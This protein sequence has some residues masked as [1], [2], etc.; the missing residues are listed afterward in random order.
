MSFLH[1]RKPVDVQD[2][3]IDEQ[4]QEEII[5]QFESEAAASRSRSRWLACSL[6]A[7]VGMLGVVCLFKGLDPHT[8]LEFHSLLR[9]GLGT[10]GLIAIQLSTLVTCGLIGK[11]VNSSVCVLR[12]FCVN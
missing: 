1:A 6:C 5:Q 2:E 7:L 11:Y 9:D 3:L 10:F 8:E 12:F 4:A